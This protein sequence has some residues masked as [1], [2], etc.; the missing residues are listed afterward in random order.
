MLCVVLVLFSKEVILTQAHLH[1]CTAILVRTL[2]DIMHSLVPYPSIKTTPNPNL[3]PILN[4]TIKQ[5]FN[6]LVKMS[7]Q[8]WLKLQSVLTNIT[9]NML[10]YPSSPTVNSEK[11]TNT[12]QNKVVLQSIKKGYSA[13]RDASDVAD[14][15]ILHNMIYLPQH[16]TLLGSS[17]VPYAC[18]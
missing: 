9:H 4:Y 12:H 6:G 1:V 3:N 13:T 10:G 8:K 2:T 5:P 11:T 18:L 16:W 7:N 15:P 17:S 14:A